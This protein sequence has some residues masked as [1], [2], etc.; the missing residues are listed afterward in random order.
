MGRLRTGEFSL[1]AGSDSKVGEMGMVRLRDGYAV[2]G[3][4]THSEVPRLYVKVV[5]SW[6][7]GG[8]WGGYLQVTRGDY[9]GYYI[10]SKDGWVAAYS[11]KYDPVTFV[12]KGDYYEIRQKRDLNGSALIIQDNKLRFRPQT[13]GQWSI[14]DV[15]G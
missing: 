13:P 4:S 8:N 5:D 12:D 14:F 2:V 9:V 6:Q 11:G 7:E 15:S 10:D 1:Y 3:H